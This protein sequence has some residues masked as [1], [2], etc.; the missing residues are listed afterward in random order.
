MMQT[1]KLNLKRLSPQQENYLLLLAAF[2]AGSLLTLAFAPFNC[3][4]MALICPTILFFL[5]HEQNH[6]LAFV[7]GSLFGIGFFTS[8]MYW[9][10]ISIHDYGHTPAWLSFLITSIFIIGFGSM[11][12]IQGYLFVKLRLAVQRRTW[13]LFFSCC[14][15][16]QECARIYFWT[17]LPWILLGYSQVGSPLG[18]LIPII[19]GFGIT[20]FIGI[21]AGIVYL[22]I[23][24]KR[25]INLSLGLAA[26]FLIIVAASWYHSGVAGSRELS[27]AIVQGNIDEDDLWHEE[28]T[29][30]NISKYH[31]LSVDLPQK[32]IVWPE[33]AIPIPYE[34]A[35]DYLKQ[36]TQI[37]KKRNQNYLIGIPIQLPNSEHYTNSIISIGTEKMQRYDKIHVIPFGEFVPLEKYLKGI[38]GLFSIPMSSFEPGSLHQPLFDIDNILMAPF[39]CYD[40]AYQDYLIH[41]ALPAAQL[42]VVVSNDAWFKHSIAADQHLQIAQFRALEVNRPVIFS[43]NSGISAII[44]NEGQVKARLPTFETKVLTGHIR[45]VR[46]DTIWTQLGGDQYWIILALLVI[47]YAAAITIARGA[48]QV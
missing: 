2:F 41:E 36:L 29:S 24:H 31:R 45:L 40:I 25:Y 28:K 9:I 20:Y 44:D 6:K 5:W 48:R 37:A 33:G 23:A 14:W 1:I 11:F 16:L 21:F 8:G 12:G 26:M 3:W 38:I 19:G 17:G 4:V 27:V 43:N 13:P 30:E 32:L 15:I 35:K 39:V 7:R 22:A 46:G 42:L 47:A 18:Y 10:Y 34:F